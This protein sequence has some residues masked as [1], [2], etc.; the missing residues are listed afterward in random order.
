ML[1]GSLFGWDAPA[2]DPKRYENLPPPEVNAGYTIMRKAT[3]G[4]IEIVLGQNIKRPEMFVTWRRTRAN[5]RN[6]TPDYYWG[7]Y[8]GNEQSAVVDFNSR[9]EKEKLNSKGKA[10]HTKKKTEPER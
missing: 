1:N 9:V 8:F 6:E 7:H 4:G 3:I 5:E 2:A 10:V